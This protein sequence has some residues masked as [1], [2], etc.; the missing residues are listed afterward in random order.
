VWVKP[1]EVFGPGES[2]TAAT[3]ETALHPYG[4]AAVLVV[5][6]VVKYVVTLESCALA[7]LRGYMV[8]CVWHVS[9]VLPSRM[10]ECS[11]H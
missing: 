5:E 6:S 10:R 2:V 7:C 8:C 4:G 11:C 1:L 3:S 9:V